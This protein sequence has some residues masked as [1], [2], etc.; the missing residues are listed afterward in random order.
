MFFICGLVAPGHCAP[1]LLLTYQGAL[2]DAA[3]NPATGTY[4]M[5]FRM[6]EDPAGGAALWSQTIG[7]VKVTDGVFTV[8]LG[9]ATAPLP[10][11]LTNCRYLQVSVGGTAMAPRHR[12]TSVPY[13]LEAANAG[14][15]NGREAAYYQDAG[16]LDAGTLGTARLPQIPGG[17]LVGNSVTGPK[18]ADSAVTGSKVA[19]GSLTG[20]DLADNSVGAGKIDRDGLNADLLDSKEGSDFAPATH[21]H[22][23]GT[24]T[25]Q[26][27]A[28]QIADGAVAGSKIAFGTTIEGSDAVQGLSL[29]NDST[30]ASADGLLVVTKGQGAALKGNAYATSGT[31]RG[32]YALA[33]CATGYALAAR[34]Y[35][36]SG[37][38]LFVEAGKSHFMDPVTM[39]STLSVAGFATFA[40]G[41]GDLAENYR[42]RGVEAGDVVVIGKGGVLAKC[43]REMD[44][45]VAGIVSTQPSMRLSGRI[46]DGEGV[47]PLALVGRVLCK[48]DATKYPIR[49]GDL[50]TTSETPG[51]AMKALSA[52][53]AAGAVIGKALEDLDKGTGVIQVLVTLR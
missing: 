38:A 36:S 16:N 49:A 9:G 32:V 21:G 28:A 35:N 14:T 48:V 43:S 11:G 13:A 39:N 18:I 41:H 1:P 2:T 30:G 15:L 4:S 7:S 51:H 3:G 47:V 20:A 31:P 40:G 26:V 25:G 17:K 23:L 52:R 24:L 37:Y 46:D 12:L 50:L 6:Y 19:D 5:T 45:A 8:V 33:N 27:Q 53:R 29:W 10:A 34:N 44:T 42:G 22:A